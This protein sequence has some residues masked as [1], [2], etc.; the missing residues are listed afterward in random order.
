MGRV[1]SRTPLARGKGPLS[2]I[3]YASM[4]KKGQE[5]KTPT[6]RETCT[7]GCVFQG[8]SHLALVL[9]SSFLPSFRLSCFFD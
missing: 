8:V 6:A 1:V 9:H 4:G 7:K 2:N 3:W 5:K